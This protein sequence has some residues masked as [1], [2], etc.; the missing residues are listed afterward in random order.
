MTEAIRRLLR[1]F[2][3]G[4]ALSGCTVDIPTPAPSPTPAPQPAP[5]TETRI[6]ALSGPVAFGEVTVGTTK[7][8]PLIVLNIGNSPLSIAGISGGFAETHVSATTGTVPAGGNMTLTFSFTPTTAGTRSADLIINSDS[9]SGNNATTMSGTGVTA[10]PP[11]ATGTWTGGA[12]GSNCR[13]SGP[14]AGTDYC[15]DNANIGGPL[16]MTFA[17]AVTGAVTGTVTLIDYRASVSGSLNGALLQVNGTGNSGFLDH[18]YAN[19]N[20]TINGNTMTGTFIFRFSAKNPDG[21]VEWTMTL[22]SVT[23]Q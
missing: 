16:M 13:Q 14:L 18:E 23:R 2:L 10:G 11:T 6:I 3:L 19:W 21:F 17:Q 1:V 4:C 5:V 8:V 22:A 15:R 9:T 7:T 20:T 12:M